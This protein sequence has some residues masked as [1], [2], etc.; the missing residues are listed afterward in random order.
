MIINKEIKL[1]IADF[2]GTLVDTFQANYH[3]YRKAFKKNG[4]LELTEDFYKECFGLRFEAFMDKAKIPNNFIRENIRK[5]KM[6]AY[7]SFFDMLKPNETL[8]NFIKS[9]KK[10]GG[11]TAIAS[12]ARKEN[13]MKVVEYLQ[14]ESTFDIILSGKD[15]T[16]GKPDPEIYNKVLEMTG[17]DADN[18]LVFEDSEIGVKAA[19]AAGISYIKINSDYYGD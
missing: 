16:R 10:A 9:F 5:D 4:L 11:K 12:T 8:I 18:A 7:T 14:L 2:D 3:A 17:T 15:V 19:E 6:E 1:L 13:L